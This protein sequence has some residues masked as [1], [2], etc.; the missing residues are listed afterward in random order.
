M[1][2]VI[3]D[4]QTLN[5]GDNPWTGL[6]GPDE[7]VIHPRTSR[8][9]ILERASSAE[10]LVTNKAVLDAEILAQ[11][12]R[13]KFIAVTATGYNVVDVNA[14][15]QRGIPVSNVPSYGTDTV[16]QYAMALILELCHHVGD[17]ADSVAKGVWAAS[18]DWTYWKCPQIEL[19]GLTLGIVGFGRIGQRVGELGHAFGMRILYATEPPYYPV[20]YPASLVSI[21]TLFSEA[22]IV[23]L[24]CSLDKSNFEFI[25]KALLQKMKPTAFLINAA[26]GQLIKE[27][28]LADALR[29]GVLAGAALDVL[30]SEPPSKDNPLLSAPHCTITPHMAWASLAARRR[31][32]QTTVANIKAFLSGA[33]INV[34]NPPTP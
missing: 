21:E 25:N 32:V 12:P 13:L 8:E 29:D 18:K 30:S 1:K 2:I 6:D 31:I 9:E 7:L 11:L 28:D 15:R 23:T 4:D 26:R 3:L 22:D 16:A 19:R 34:V 33:P 17:H 20:N 14:S 24:H 10:I 5:P 27:Q